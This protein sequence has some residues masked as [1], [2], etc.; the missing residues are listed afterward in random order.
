MINRL[1]KCSFILLV[2]FAAFSITRPGIVGAGSTPHTLPISPQCGF[3]PDGYFYLKGE[4]PKGFED[5]DYVE[6][7]ALSNRKRPPSDSRLH[8][9]DGKSY[10]FTRL[11]EFD[12]HSSGSGITFG[13]ETEIIESVRYQFSGK[14]ISICIFS[15]DET[16]PKKVVADGRL[17]KFVDGKGVATAEVQFTYS[18][19]QRPRS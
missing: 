11:A 3:N 1:V 9:Q 5:F 10:K 19:S 6:L 17:T 16:D 13:F 2:C 12:T 14:F 8:T 7:M 18:K 15:E 4:L